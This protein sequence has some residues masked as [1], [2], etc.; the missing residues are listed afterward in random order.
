MPT[1]EILPPD[2]ADN[3]SDR[4]HGPSTALAVARGGALALA[5]EAVPWGLAV[6]TFLAAAVDSPHTRR[7]YGRHL[8]DALGW[9]NVETVA[10]ITGAGLAAW[11]VE[12]I[13]RPLAPSS[14]AQALAALRRFLAWARP[15]GIHHLAGEVVREALRTPRNSVL[16]PYDVLTEPEV[17]ATLRAASTLRDRALL[18]VLLG[19]GL[20]A[21]ECCGLDVG[22]VR[23]DGDGEAV[24]YVR[25]GKGRKDR[26][27]PVRAE[28]VGAIRAYL[29]EAGRRL[30]DAGP[31]FL[32]EDR[33]AWARASRRITPRA[34][35]LI[36]ERVKDRARITGKAFSPHAARH[37]FAIRALRGGADVVKVAR[38]LGHSDVRVTMRYVDHLGLGELRAAVAPLPM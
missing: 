37:T 27:V 10:E 6:E 35:G 4:E 33:A 2:A 3:R 32:A 13:G 18:A 22:D 12:L 38:L 31:L 7:A 14:Q 28:V 29:A 17:G 25:R 8:A 26:A 11:R 9:L 24:L 23:E 1:P 5:A 36:V 15:F 34:V 30:G 21:A 19:G 16:R 20:R